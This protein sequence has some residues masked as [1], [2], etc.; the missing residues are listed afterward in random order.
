MDA[1][2]AERCEM[3]STLSNGFL[4]VSANVFNAGDV[5]QRSV[6]W[7]IPLDAV[8]KMAPSRSTGFDFLVRSRSFGFDDRFSGSTILVHAIS[9]G[10]A[11][12]C[13]RAVLVG[14]VMVLRDL[15][16]AA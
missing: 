8:E 1:D 5:F 3:L 11:P 9:S 16:R 14:V 15:E 10:Y 12:L 4:R 7:R 6:I 2:A 13:E